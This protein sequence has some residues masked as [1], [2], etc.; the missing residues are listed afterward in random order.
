MLSC[1]CRAAHTNLLMFAQTLL[2]LLMA[3]CFMLFQHTD[4]A[5]QLFTVTTDYF[6]RTGF[7]FQY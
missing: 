5:Q 7:R 3:E 4:Q 2:D 1:I 6:P